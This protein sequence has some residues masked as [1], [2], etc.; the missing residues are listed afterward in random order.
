MVGMHQMA[1]FGIRPELDFAGYQM[2]YPARTESG[3]ST[4][5]H[6]ITYIFELLLCE[7]L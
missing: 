3:Q 4:G 2:R 7:S 6:F 1:F 5:I